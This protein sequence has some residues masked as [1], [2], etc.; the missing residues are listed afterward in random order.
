[1]QFVLIVVCQPAAPSVPVALAAAEPPTGGH[2]EHAG[3]LTAAEPVDESAEILARAQR[4]LAEIGA[5]SHATDGGSAA[6]SG[7]YAERRGFSWEARRSTAGKARGVGGLS[8]SEAAQLIATHGGDAGLVQR[9][10]TKRLQSAVARA[11]SKSSGP[12]NASAA[13]QAAAD[14][15]ERERAAALLMDLPPLGKPSFEVVLSDGS[16]YFLGMREDAHAQGDEA[17]AGGV[18]SDVAAAHAAATPGGLLSASGGILGAPMSAIIREA[19]A[20]RSKDAERMRPP[21]PMPPPLDADAGASHSQIEPSVALSG[22]AGAGAGASSSSSSASASAPKGVL[23]VDKYA[24]RTFAELLSSE[25]VNRTVLRWVLLWNER[26]FT[27]GRARAQRGEAANHARAGSASSAS[28]AAAAGGSGAGAASAANAAGGGGGGSAG[29]SSGVGAKRPASAI[30]SFL[31]GPAAAK[32]L[33][34]TAAAA[35]AGGAGGPS[36]SGGAAAGAQAVGSAAMP[37]WERQ[38]VLLLCGPPGAGKTTLVRR[39]TPA[40]ITHA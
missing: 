21:V 14:A 24:P 2:A 32:R 22:G 36:G 1:M 39:G 37:P 12:S 7:S 3:A 6:L 16:M 40:M 10:L 25:A 5:S 20:M 30:G 26:V 18:S 28:S 13:A 17:A 35:A 9:V 34:E 29:G 4:F 31:A 15:A 33:K 8:T 23:W 27:A 38:R 19:Q 11:T